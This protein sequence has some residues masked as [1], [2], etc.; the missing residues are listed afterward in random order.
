MSRRM[1]LGLPQGRQG[2]QGR[3]VMQAGAGDDNKE[4]DA[5]EEGAESQTPSETPTKVSWG[6]GEDNSALLPHD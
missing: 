4:G 5:V 3:W 2:R 6:L 1:G